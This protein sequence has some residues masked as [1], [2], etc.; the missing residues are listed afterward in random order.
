MTQLILPT[1]VFAKKIEVRSMPDLVE[2]RNNL[3]TKMDEL[4]KKAK[5]ETRSLSEE[6]N[7]EFEKAKQ[8]VEQ[9][10][11][12]LQA[13]QTAKELNN[14]QMQQ[15][16]TPE[17]EEKRSLDE[18]NFLKFIK[19]EERALDVSGN[20]GIIPETIADRIIM[21]VKELHLSMHFQQCLT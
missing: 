8:E 6:E 7:T 2:Q 3:L 11:K 14:K 9:I 4:V 13:E 17:A 12:T 19:G 18:T 1:N 21:R 20:G 10:D 16:K 15:A 5:E